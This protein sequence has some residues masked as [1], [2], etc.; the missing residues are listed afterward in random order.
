VDSRGLAASSVVVG[1]VLTAAGVPDCTHKIVF[2]LVSDA[3][4]ADLKAYER[5]HGV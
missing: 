2:A 3:A 1:N 4:I 5:F